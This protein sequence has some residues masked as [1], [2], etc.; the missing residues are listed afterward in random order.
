MLLTRRWL[1][2]PTTTTGMGLQMPPVSFS[3]ASNKPTLRGVVFDMDGT[4]TVPAIDFH[5]MYRMVLGNDHPDIKSGNSSGIDIL[6]QI[7]DWSPDR[8][9]K[10][11]EIITDFERQAHQRLQIMPG[12]PIHTLRIKFMGQFYFFRIVL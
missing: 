12:N 6:Q 8:Q 1:R 5:Q 10:A 7:E 9:M 11:Y 4:L 2:R 3:T